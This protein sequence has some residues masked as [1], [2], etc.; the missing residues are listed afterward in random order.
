MASPAHRVQEDFDAILG[1]YMRSLARDGAHRG[2]SAPG[3]T[4][5]TCP[6]C[7]ARTRFALDPEGTWFRCNRCGHYA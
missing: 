3:Y 5:R 7:G 1:R 6:A 2:A 4:F